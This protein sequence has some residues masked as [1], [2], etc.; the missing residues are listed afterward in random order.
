MTDTQTN[1][2]C[3][4][5]VTLPK[6]G[7]SICIFDIHGSLSV[8]IYLKRILYPNNHNGHKDILQGRSEERVTKYPKAL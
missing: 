4:R 5:K 6:G 8:L 3:H 1:R 7:Q 2:P